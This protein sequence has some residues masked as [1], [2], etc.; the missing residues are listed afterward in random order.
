MIQREKIEFHLVDL[1]ESSEEVGDE[2]DSESETIGW[3][4]NRVTL[5]WW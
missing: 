5:Q 1:R 2:L 3:V 4:V